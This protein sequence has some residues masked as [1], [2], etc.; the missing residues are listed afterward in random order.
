MYSPPSASKPKFSNPPTPP[1]PPTQT[2]LGNI[3]PG[4]IDLF[5]D[6]RKHLLIN[7]S[8]E[9]LAL[10]PQIAQYPSLHFEAYGTGVVS[11]FTADK[12]PM[13]PPGGVSKFG[14]PAWTIQP[15]GTRFDPP[16]EVTLP[17]RDGLPAGDNV[18]IV[19]WDHDLSQYTAIGRATVSEDGSVLV[20]DSGSGLAKAGW[21]GAGGGGGGGGV[22]LLRMGI[23][24]GRVGHISA[25]T[26][27]GWI[28]VGLVRAAWRI[29]IK[30]MRSVMA[31]LVRDAKGAVAWRSSVS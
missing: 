31:M 28:R 8:V 21:G 10:N 14:V 7:A 19:Q 16:I 9:S 23:S 22:G 11:P 13:S 5:V 26:V 2:T 29:P 1:K 15:A 20:C 12:L 24:V 3:P 4:R 25:K 30:M 27:S 18:A 17:N 6:G